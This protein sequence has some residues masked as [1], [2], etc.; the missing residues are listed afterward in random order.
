MLGRV[1]SVTET[2]EGQ[3]FALGYLRCKRAGRQVNLE[4]KA[5]A[6]LGVGDDDRDQILPASAAL[7]V[8]AL[9]RDKSVCCSVR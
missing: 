9:W 8:V 5:D 6:L 4:G 3:K 1:T 2:P 7:S